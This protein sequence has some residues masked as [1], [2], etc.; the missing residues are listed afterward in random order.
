MSPPG[1][2]AVSSGTDLGTPNARSHQQEDVGYRQED[3]PNFGQELATAPQ[4]EKGFA[5]VK[6]EGIEDADLGWDE[7][8]SY[9]P[10]PLIGG[11]SNDELWTLIRRFN[12]QMFQVRAETDTVQN[13]TLC[14]NIMEDEAFHIEKLRAHIERLYITVAFG[15]F[16]CWKQI[17]RLRSWRER[18]RTSAFLALY[19]VAWL[20]DLLLPST[21]AFMMVLILFVPARK[22]CFP[23]A[24]PALIDGSTGGVQK[25]VSGVLASED[26]MTGAPEKRPGEAIEQEA[27]SFVNSVATLAAGIASAIEPRD[28]ANAKDKTGGDLPAV[29]PDKTKKPVLD[30]VV[31]KARPAM[32]QIANFVDAYERLSNAL[33]PTPPFPGTRPRVIL[34]ASLIPLL[35]G[36]YYVSSYMILKGFGFIVGFVLFGQPAI[37]WASEFTDRNYPQLSHNLKLRNGI[38][39]G[40]PTNAQLTLTL[41]RVGERNRAPLPPPPSIHTRASVEEHPDAKKTI[42]DL[43]LEGVTEAEIHSAVSPDDNLVQED[44]E[45]QNK[46]KPKKGE[47]ILGFFKGIGR[48]GIST[49]LRTDRL[50]AATG[51]T[52]AKDRLGAVKS[53][54][55]A[56]T[57]PSLF[58]ARFDGKPGHMYIHTSAVAPT[59]VWRPEK[60][61]GNATWGISIADIHE[62]EKTNGLDWKTK[63]AVGWAKEKE[64][65]DGIIIKDRAGQEYTITAIPLR[66]EFFN[67]LIAI[68]GQK[69]KSF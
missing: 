50:R 65:V 9:T 51:S 41:L 55:T 14:M 49:A 69:W 52:N 62:I 37:Q 30:M 54:P 12:K 7:E 44:D 8:A 3:N 24:P 67:R 13:E 39:N 59:V 31:E 16:S 43:E 46:P 47:R 42:L 58:M 68:G 20:F 17:A 6:H 18:N 35:L 26:S 32:H 27:H 63:I 4:I 57:G 36:S 40:V 33:S 21:F 5:Q 19:C 61:D 48:A 28:I 10:G 38:L 25:P 53:K 45:S 64:V 22:L 29:E 2:N 60:N 34:A 11:L 1:P 66:D 56:P 23:P 15:I